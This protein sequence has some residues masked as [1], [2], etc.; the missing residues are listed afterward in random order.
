MLSLVENNG[1]V[2]EPSCGDGAFSNRIKNCVAIEYDS[3]KCPSYALNM[4]FFDYPITEKF[5]TIVGNSPYVK[6]KSINK[7]TKSKLDLELFDTRTNLYLFFIYKCV[8]HLNDGGELIFIHKGENT[9][10]FS[11]GRDKTFNKK[12]MKV[13]EKCY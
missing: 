5:D 2:L 13:G 10:D 6:Y 4:D 9:R 11:H 12:G 7:E 8:L 3:S 1:R